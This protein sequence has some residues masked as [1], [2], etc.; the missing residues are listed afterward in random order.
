M[1]QVMEMLATGHKQYFWKID[2]NYIN[3]SLPIV[4]Y[5]AVPAAILKQVLKK[6]QKETG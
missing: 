5:R 2:G 4:P 1:K 3:T 6:E